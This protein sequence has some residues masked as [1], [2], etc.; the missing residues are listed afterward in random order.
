MGARG[1]MLEN[2]TS[3]DHEATVK[4]AEADGHT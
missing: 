2:D 4:T 3:A 1:A